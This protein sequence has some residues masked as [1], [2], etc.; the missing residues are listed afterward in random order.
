[1]FSGNPDLLA[2]KLMG[3]WR[4][5][6]PIVLSPEKDDPNLSSENNFLYTTK[7]PEGQLCPIGAHIRRANPRDAFK[8][9][10]KKSLLFTKKHRILRRSRAY[11]QPLDANLEPKKMLESSVQDT[12]RGIFFIAIN[13][14]LGR[15]F[16][17]VQ[18]TWIND[19]K[20]LNFYNEPDALIGN[21][22]MEK[23]NIETKFTVPEKCLRTEISGTGGF[24]RTRGSAY[25][26]LPSLNSLKFLTLLP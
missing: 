10:P 8:E 17:F 6:A 4:N 12:N 26:F 18:Q 1:M 24:V 9:D 16:E 22:N 7:D 5:G 25:F 13:A 2:A 11:G 15:Q 23:D 20:F 3:R 14:N 19:P 21:S